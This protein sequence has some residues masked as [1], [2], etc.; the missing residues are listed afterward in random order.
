MHNKVKTASC[1]CCECRFNEQYNFITDSEAEFVTP[2]TT[3]LF[4]IEVQNIFIKKKTKK[5]RC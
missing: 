1:R 2:V 5:K 4:Y 3:V